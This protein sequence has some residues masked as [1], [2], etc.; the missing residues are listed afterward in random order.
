MES[1]LKKCPHGIYHPD[2]QRGPYACS[3]CNLSFDASFLKRKSMPKFIMPR[4]GVAL[5]TSR[6]RANFHNPDSCPACTSYI[7]IEKKKG[8]S[9][10]VVCA[11]CGK[12]YTRKHSRVGTE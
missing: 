8:N 7:R 9:R 3:F 12:E 1:T 4:T 6:L 10:D 2:G 5:D 11:D